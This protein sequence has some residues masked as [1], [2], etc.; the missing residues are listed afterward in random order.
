MEFTKDPSTHPANG[1]LTEER[2]IRVRDELA[3][4]A[5][6][7]D[8]GNL[9]YMMAD[10]SKAIDELLERRK[11][12]QVPVA[13]VVAWHHPTEERTCDIRLLRHDLAPGPLYAAPQLPQPVVP[14]TLPCPVML[15]PGLRFGKGV[16]TQ[17]MLN[18][19]QRRAEYYADLEAMTPEQRADHDAGMKEFAAMLQGAEPVSQPYTLPAEVR[20]AINRL[21]DSDGSRGTFSAVRSYDAREELERMIAAAPQQEA[22]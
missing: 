7:S 10:A 3:A 8:G 4:A 17:T 2:L 21:L 12:A 14:E 18:A 11:A 9:G 13:D 16:R 20:D 5:K 19:L 15:E 1:P 6:H 22:E